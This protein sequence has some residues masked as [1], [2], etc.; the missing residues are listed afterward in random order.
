MNKLTK[1]VIAILGGVNV[2][3]S[4]FMPIAVGLLSV[5]YFKLTGYHVFLVMGLAILSTTYRAIDVGY[6]RG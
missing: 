1:I 5:S 6:L 2:V 4:M 3:F